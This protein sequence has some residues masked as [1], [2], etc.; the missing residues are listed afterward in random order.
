MN[1]K[2]D[3]VVDALLK[4]IRH[5]ATRE[6]RD[7]AAVRLCVAPPDGARVARVLK[8]ALPDVELEVVERAGDPRVLMVSFP[9]EN[10]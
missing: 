1:L 5:L 6:G 10:E 9:L 2:V 3:W 4:Q 8:D 7:P